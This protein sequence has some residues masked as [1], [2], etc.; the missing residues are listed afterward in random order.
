MQGRHL[1][2]PVDVVDF[3]VAFVVHAGDIHPPLQVPAPVDPGRPDMLA[4]GHGHRPSRAVEFKGQLGAGGRGADHQHL[5][6]RKLVRVAVVH[7]VHGGD[8]RRRRLGHGRNPG[9]VASSG[10]QHHGA[11]VPVAPVRAHHVTVIV[12]SDRIDRGVGFDRGGYDLGVAVEE[13]DGFGH[14]PVAVRVVALIVESGQPALPVGGQQA[15]RIPALGAPRVGHR[16]ALEDDMVDGALG[17]AA[18]HGEP[19]LAGADD[20]GGDL[21]NWTGPKCGLVTLSSR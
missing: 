17:Q 2:R 11:A 6:R 19:R 5:T 13:G 3:V 18:A 4:H 21:A 1:A 7:G 10:G 16:A 15:E 9:N 20:D 12:E 14:V 8:I